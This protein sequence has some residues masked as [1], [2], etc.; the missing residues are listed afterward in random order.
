MEAE[1]S[2]LARLAC[3]MAIFLAFVPPALADGDN[4]CLMC[5]AD[6]AGKK[7]LHPALDMGCESC[8]AKLDTS[9]MPHKVRGKVA[10]G[11][12]AEVPGLCFG[13][14]DKGMFEKRYVHA[15]VAGG[16]CLDCH[17]PH[18][19][20]NQNL[21][22]KEP[23]ETCLECHPEV[24]VKGHGGLS[25]GPHPLGF[26]ERKLMD[27]KREGKPFYC[28]S[29]HDPHSAEHPKQTRYGKGMTGCAQCHDK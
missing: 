7:V 5:H 24:R 2:L 8:H 26:E 12:S 13:C 20:G 4:P 9:V 25:L 3:V 29:C 1:K 16:L 15:P 10:K 18:S 14:H 23:V 21:L 17:D 22:L 27:P 6:V 19:S 28:G 11:L